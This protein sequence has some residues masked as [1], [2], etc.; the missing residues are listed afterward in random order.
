MMI[1][2]KPGMQNEKIAI[3]ALVIIIIGALSL[4]FITAYGED[5]LDN[6]F[7]E[8][9][10][11]TE[12]EVIALGDC[13]DVNYIGRYASNGTVFDSSYDFVENKSGGTPLKMFININQSETSPMVGYTGIIEGLAEGLIGLKENDTATIGPIPPEKAYGAKKLGIGDSFNTS[14]QFGNSLCCSFK[15]GLSFYVATVP[16]G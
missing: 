7:G 9:R 8:I 11:E 16:G 14:N 1:S 6:L 3:I 2:F 5:I 12:P 4:F 10:E 13:V 15:V